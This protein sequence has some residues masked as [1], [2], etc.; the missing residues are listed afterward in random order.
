MS[1][2]LRSLDLNLLP[3]FDVLMSEQHLSRASERLAMSQPAVSNALK[4]L[5]ETFND[6]LFVRTS[7]G[8]KPTPRAIALHEAVLPALRQIQLGC[9]EQEFDATKSSQTMRLTMNAAVEYLFG[10]DFIQ[11][12]RRKAPF[13]KL[14]LHPDHLEEIPRL[15]KE[16]RL[17]VVLDYVGYNEACFR[18]QTLVQEDLTVICAANHP[19]VKGSISIEQFETLPQVTLVPRSNYMQS[20]S[21][22]SGTPIEQLMGATLPHRNVFMYVSSFVAVPAI[23]LQ[24]DLIAVVPERLVKQFY[25]ADQLQQLPLPFPYPKANIQLIWH[26]S[27]D[28][29]PAHQWLRQCIQ[30]AISQRG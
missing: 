6:E 4:R 1:L 23:V 14:Q 20:D 24:S 11:D 27:R 5:R 13:M 21:G 29:D 26:K 15:L 17:D 25:L 9:D 12:V 3:V 7:R 8:L 16:G 22:R 19:E 10:P 2:N 30:Q 18:K 28:N